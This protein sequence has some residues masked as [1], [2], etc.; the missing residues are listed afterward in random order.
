MLSTQ[1]QPDVNLRRLTEAHHVGLILGVLLLAVAERGHRDVGWSELPVET[2]SLKPG[3]SRSGFERFR[4]L[5]LGAFKT[6]SLHRPT[7]IW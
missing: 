1:G 4:A 6:Y 5:N 7:V 3:S 2:S